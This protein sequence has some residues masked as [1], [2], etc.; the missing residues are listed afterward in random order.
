MPV[1]TETWKNVPAALRS[2][3]EPRLE[4]GENPCTW[5]ET[6]LD[7]RLHYVRNFVVLTD[8]RVLGI[9]ERDAVRDGSPRPLDPATFQ[10]WPLASVASLRAIEQGALGTLELVGASSRLERWHFTVNRAAAA[11]RLVER[12]TELRRAQS[13]AGLPAAAVW[14]SVRRA[15]NP[16][17]R[18]ASAARPARP[19]R[20]D[21]RRIRCTACCC[22]RGRGR[23]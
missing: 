3:I 18:V 14:P 21:L 7:R 16:F 10:S 6:D 20:R 12:F 11:R 23:R 2:A 8:R 13:T 15:V 4:P 1:A 17:R 22:L 9:T 5:F 19:P